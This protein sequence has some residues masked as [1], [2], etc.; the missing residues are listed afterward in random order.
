MTSFVHSMPFGT[1]VR[2]D[3]TVRFGIW[4]PGRE[5]ISLVLGG[6]GGRTLPMARRG[7][8]GHF[9]L[10]TDGAPPGTRYRFELTDGVRVPDP[11]SRHQ[12]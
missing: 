9:E 8:D 5:S 11:I 3:G 7:D 4:A 2:P 10:T 6:D 1:D 12:P